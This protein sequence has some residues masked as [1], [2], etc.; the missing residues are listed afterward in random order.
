M[1]IS[2][3]V[4]I[5]QATV[6][7]QEQANRYKPSLCQDK[8]STLSSKSSLITTSGRFNDVNQTLTERS[9]EPIA[10]QQYCCVFGLPGFSFF[11]MLELKRWK[12][13]TV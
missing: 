5:I 4:N 7:S 11:N 10:L 13:E 12:V 3:A 9:R 6:P 8:S 1:P 2:D